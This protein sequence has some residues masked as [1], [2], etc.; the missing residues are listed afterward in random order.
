MKGL[1]MDFFLFHDN[2]IVH[3]IPMMVY[4]VESFLP[5]NCKFCYVF[6]EIQVTCYVLIFMAKDLVIPEG[7]E[8]FFI[9]PVAGMN[10]PGN[11]F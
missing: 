1:D 9:R 5:K 10:V 6:D 2:R 8:S 3:R 7:M 11:I 4:P